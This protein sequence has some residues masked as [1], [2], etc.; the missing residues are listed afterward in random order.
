MD[1]ITAGLQFLVPSLIRSCVC[2]I[3]SRPERALLSVT[4]M[5][6]DVD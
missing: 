3:W 2:V 6:P 1:E 4:T 5:A